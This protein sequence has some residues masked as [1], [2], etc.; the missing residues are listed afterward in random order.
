MMKLSK[1][2]IKLLENYSEISNS[3]LIKP[4]SV[5]K[6]ICAEEIILAEAEVPEN[7]PKSFA[8]YELKKFLR[9]LVIQNDAELDFEESDSY[10]IIRD[11]KH[12]L[13]YYYC[14]LQFVKDCYDVE[15]DVPDDF[16][17]FRLEHSQLDRLIKTTS[18]YTL[19]NICVVSQ[20]GTIK[21]VAKD[22]EN[23]TSTE[24][25]IEVGTSNRNFDLTL[26]P[27]NLKIIP[28]SYD[29]SLYEDSRLLKFYSSSRKLTYYIA[30]EQD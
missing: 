6:T 10:V 4:G 16:I 23:P 15:I 7:F 30:M 27:E 12:K 11:G 8:I 26:K 17:E 21:L 3:I 5:I 29:V 20:A 28:G 1:E 24:F 13:K 9:G 25:S 14:D 2:T 18:I 22:R 19:P